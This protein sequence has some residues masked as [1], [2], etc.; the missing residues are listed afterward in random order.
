M[1][2]GGVWRVVLVLRLE[3]PGMY[4]DRLFTKNQ[5][6]RADTSTVAGVSCVRPKPSAIRLTV[7]HGAV[8]G[9]H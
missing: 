6:A 9:S 3:H 1:F 2:N 8:M 7:Y 4:F 5:N